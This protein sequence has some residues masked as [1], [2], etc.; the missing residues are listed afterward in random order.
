EVE[1]GQEDVQA[2]RL[3]EPHEVEEDEGDDDHDAADDVPGVLTKRA[4]EDGQVVRHEERRDGD[5]DDVIEHLRPRGRERDELVKGMACEA[6]RAA[7]FREP[8]GSLRIRRRCGGEDQAADDEDERCES[9][10]DSRHEPERVVDRGADVP[11]RGG[12]EGRRAEHPLESLLPSSSAAPRLRCRGA[13]VGRLVDEKAQRLVTLSY[14]CLAPV[15]TRGVA[16][17]A[18][19]LHSSC[20]SRDGVVTVP[21]T[22]MTA[23]PSRGW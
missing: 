9:E 15:R 13:H 11:V 8:D 21:G 5:R 12:E 22:G 4:P 2:G 3:P 16:S 18:A 14:R 6:R 1:Y 19:M 7:R 20:E 10:R 23:E 17:Y